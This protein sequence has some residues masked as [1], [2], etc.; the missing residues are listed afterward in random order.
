MKIS[1]S[2]L[3]AQLQNVLWIGGGACGGKTT[4]TDLLARK[5]GLLP[6]H[7]EE[8]LDVHKR[9]ASAEDHPA[10]FARF[11]GWEWYFNR[12]ID[13]YVQAT[14]VVGQEQFEMV[15]LDLVRLSAQSRVIIDGFLLDAWV[16][17][18]LTEPDKVIFLFADEETIRK[19]FFDRSDKQDLVELLN[20]LR[21]PVGTREHVLQMVCEHSARKR[22]TAEA[23][24]FKV[25]LR[26]RDMTFEDAVSA[27][28]THFGFVDSHRCS[29]PKFAL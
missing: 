9:A 13:E 25:I 10:L 5:H 21:D 7:P 4:L 29:P 26:N 18:H 19:C 2:F 14:D 20:T 6:Y 23:V 1:D 27:A 15:V 17:K 12:P 28:E 22:K 11:H 16:L 8:L 24:G 3:K